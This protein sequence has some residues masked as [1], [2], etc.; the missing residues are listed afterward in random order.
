MTIQ[1]S[2]AIKFSDIENEFGVSQ[3]RSLSTYYG[4]DI[5]VIPS[6]GSIKFSN[7]YGSIINARR[8]ISSVQNFNARNDFPNAS[9]VGGLKSIST[10]INNNQAVKFIISFNG[11]VSASDTSQSAFDTG[12][13]FPTGS[14]IYL[15]NN[16]YIVGA[17]GAG[18][19]NSG[20]AGGSGGTAITLRMPTYIQNNGVIAGGGGG[21][22][23]NVDVDGF[24]T[25][26][27]SCNQVVYSKTTSRGGGGG[28]GAGS[29]VGKGGTIN[30]SSGTLITGGNGGS[31]ETTTD[32][33]ARAVSGAGAK[34]GDLG[35]AGSNCTGGGAGGAAGKYINGQS[36]LIWLKVG[37]VAGGIS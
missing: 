15:I 20:G 28:G 34:G 36:Y 9:I 1:S 14:S 8:N 27:Y 18:G 25:E 37:T 16:N 26:Y 4:F 11:L 21:G 2:G 10:V 6:G 12:Q 32:G 22:G 24:W 7:F 29:V 23:A 5:G 17:G 3:S 30:G 31:G 19:N 35:G 13:G 33:S